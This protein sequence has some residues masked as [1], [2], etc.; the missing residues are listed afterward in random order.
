[1]EETKYMKFR[2]L[3]KHPKRPSKTPQTTPAFEDNALYQII[4]MMMV[5][6]TI[7]VIYVTGRMY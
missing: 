5:I 7:I 4:I 2:D 1:M 6:I 3:A